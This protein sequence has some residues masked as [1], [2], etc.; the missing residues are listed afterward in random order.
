[1]DVENCRATVDFSLSKN[2]LTA[3]TS[4]GFVGGV[5]GFIARDSSFKD[6]SATISFTQGSAQKVSGVGF[7]GCVGKHPNLT[8]NLSSPGC[9]TL[10]LE[11]TNVFSGTIK[12]EPVSADNVAPSGNLGIILGSITIK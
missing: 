6:C 7:V 5:A 4:I 2:N 12:D 10:T 11:G 8:A 3:A 9:A 1:M